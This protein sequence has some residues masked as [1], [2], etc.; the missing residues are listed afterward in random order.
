MESL[1]ESLPGALLG[2]QKNTSL[3]LDGKLP[4]REGAHPAESLCG[5][6]GLLMSRESLPDCPGLL[7]AQVQGLVLLS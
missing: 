7:G 1:T 4:L 5:L 2:I 6:Q 3:S